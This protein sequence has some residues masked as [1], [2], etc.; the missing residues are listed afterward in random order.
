MD[1]CTP[2]FNSFKAI[3]E[4]EAYNI[5]MNLAKKSYALVP[6][7]TPT[8]L[9]FKCIHVLLLVITKMIL[10]ISLDSGHFPLGWREAFVLPIHLLGV[11]F[12]V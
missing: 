7:P 2:S 3:T 12:H 1:P 10:N 9:V 6:T 4:D 11:R 8:P 5:I